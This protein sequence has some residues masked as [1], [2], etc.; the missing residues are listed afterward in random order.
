MST[1][2]KN[3]YEKIN[4]IL[5]KYVTA[6]LAMTLNWIYMTKEMK[7]KR[8]LKYFAILMIVAAVVLL[9][10]IAYESNSSR[11]QSY[12]ESEANLVK[13]IAARELE[14]YP[15]ILTAQDYLTLESMSIYEN[16]MTNLRPLE[17]LPNLKKI[18]F[19]INAGSKYDFRPLAKF[20]KLKTLEIRTENLVEG[21]SFLKFPMT[22]K[23]HWYGRII[24]FFK[25]LKP[26][27]PG[28]MSF[29]LDRLGKLKQLDSLVIGGFILE[30]VDALANLTNLESLTLEN[31]PVLFANKYF[32]SIKY[33]EVPVDMSP[34]GNLTKL[35]N[36]KIT[37]LISTDY[38]FL[39]KLPQLKE[40]KL[41]G[42]QIGDM[43]DLA[44]L[45]N[46]EYLDISGI[47]AEDVSVLKTLT[48]LKSLRMEGN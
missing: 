30:N 9:F 40:L 28:Q 7:K 25:R 4:N 21:Y 18:V 31:Y 2:D 10:V 32:T 11:T 43:N 24:S 35:K 47:K 41:V 5:H 20:E 38:S 34:L 44:E 8:L 17:K 16:E 19:Y 23:E 36:L 33:P 15:P 37:N 6:F 29:N 26:A 1:D 14:Q 13:M 48:G 45:T 3:K 46:L 42:H 39:K 12:K 27:M 22:R